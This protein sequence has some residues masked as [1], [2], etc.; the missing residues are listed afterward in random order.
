MQITIDIDEETFNALNN[1]YIAYSHDIYAMTLGLEDD[2]TPMLRPL[3]EK[4]TD[5]ELRARLDKL[6]QFYLSIQQK[7][8]F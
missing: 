5:E 4:R 8:N 3:R 7:T 6:K 2:I 1:A